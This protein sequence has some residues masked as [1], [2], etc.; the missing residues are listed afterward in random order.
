MFIAPRPVKL[1]QRLSVKAVPGLQG[2]SVIALKGCA[3][4][5]GSGQIDESA[6]LARGALALEAL[7]HLV[8]RIESWAI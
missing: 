5:C 2:F 8:G 3:E 1:L 7:N 4:S 6:E